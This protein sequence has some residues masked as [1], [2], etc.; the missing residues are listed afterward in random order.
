MPFII[1]EIDERVRNGD[2]SGLRIMGLVSV[3][4]A[5]GL[6]GAS[7]LHTTERWLSDAFRDAITQRSSSAG[8]QRRATQ[9]AAAALLRT[10]DM[11]VLSDR[12]GL[13]ANSSGNGVWPREW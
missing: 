2:F 12:T 7:L 13:V 10:I 5:R 4:R 11:H 9:W 6:S 8:C 1:D 3:T